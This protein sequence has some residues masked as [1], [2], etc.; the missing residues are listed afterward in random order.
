VKR[1]K[2]CFA[3]LNSCPLSFTTVKRA[4]LRRDD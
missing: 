1:M 3:I 2:T 4:F